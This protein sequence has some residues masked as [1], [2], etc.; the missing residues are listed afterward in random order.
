MGS[1]SEGIFAYFMINVDYTREELVYN[2]LRV[3]KITEM[4]ANIFEN[5]E[6]ISS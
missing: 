3:P 4:N 6:D 5:N 2:F 1:C